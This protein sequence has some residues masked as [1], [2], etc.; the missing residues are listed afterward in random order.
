MLNSLKNTGC[1]KKS[2]YRNP[3]EQQG[4]LLNNFKSNR[5]VAASSGLG[6]VLTLLIIFI[7]T[8]SFF[9]DP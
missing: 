5:V 9:W 6:K 1:P 4:P 3:K 8:W 7:S 2:Y